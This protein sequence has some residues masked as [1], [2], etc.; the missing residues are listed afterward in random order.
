MGVE[1]GISEAWEVGLCLYSN[2]NLF[3]FNF[4]FLLNIYFLFFQL[5][6]V[7]KLVSSLFLLMELVV[8]CFTFIRSKNVALVNLAMAMTLEDCSWI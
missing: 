6:L 4:F 8:V 2:Q 1:T 5:D 7:S 3:F